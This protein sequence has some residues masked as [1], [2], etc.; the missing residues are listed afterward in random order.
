MNQQKRILLG[1]LA[2]NGDC[3]YATA[4]ARQI[5]HDFPECRLTWAIGSFCRHIIE[6]NPFVDEVWEIPVANRNDMDTAWRKFEPEA[7]RRFNMGEF[8][9]IFLTQVNPNNYQNFD[10]T[11]RSSI[12]RGYPRPITVPVTPIIRLNESEIE[13]VSSFAH[14]HQLGMYKH[15]VLFECAGASGQSFVTPQYAV[16]V[17]KIVLDHSH[18]CAFILSSNVKINSSDH[19]I[20]DGSR[21]SF[22]ENAEL[23]KYCTTIVGCSSGISW[24]STSDWAKP[25]PK[26]QLLK[27]STSVFASM[28]HDA[29]YF[30]LPTERIIEM[31]DCTQQHTADCIILALEDFTRARST[32]H[33]R[34]QV[35]LDLYLE[36]FLKTVLRSGHPLKAL[37]SLSHV[38]KRYG[39]DPFIEYI[40]RK[41]QPN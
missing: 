17:S 1:H 6:D 2:S 26:I 19:R 21:L 24:L 23:T 15:V 36:K 12:F 4:I 20:I 38:K 39:Y 33:E 16:E 34:I 37:K 3:L 32:F 5:K 31:T 41:L 30:G 14:Q 13:S 10:G 40:W 29:E 11:I 18:G 25:L 35:R 22:R 8:D 7:K 27:R 9:E 28:C